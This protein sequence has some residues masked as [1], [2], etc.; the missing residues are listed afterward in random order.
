MNSNEIASSKDNSSV[1]LTVRAA[2]L[3][4]LGSSVD[5]GI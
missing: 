2:R 1:P 3:S 5:L 4:A